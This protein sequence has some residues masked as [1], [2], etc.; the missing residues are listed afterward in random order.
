MTEI[1]KK[2]DNPKAASS[3]CYPAITVKMDD[4]FKRFLELINQILP[5]YVK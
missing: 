4:L 3:G 1:E 2:N 5:K